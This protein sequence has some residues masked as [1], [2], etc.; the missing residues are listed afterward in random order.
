M[1]RENVIVVGSGG[2]EHTLADLLK[3]EGRMIFGAP[4]NPGFVSDRP[5]NVGIDGT[6]PE[7][8]QALYDFAVSNNVGMIVVGPE[9][10]LCDGLV[11]F[12]N[13]KG[14][15]RV[16]VFGPTSQAA[17]LE[18]DKFHSY[19]INDGLGIPQAR[20]IIC[21][22]VEQ[23]PRRALDAIDALVN[24]H[25]IVLKDRGLTGGKG[26]S[27]YDSAEKARKELLSHAY[28]Y[29]GDILVAERLKGQE[30]SVFCIADGENVKPI[31][32]SFQDHKP[33]LDGDKG[34]NTGGM[35]AYGPA[36]IADRG[37]VARVCGKIAGPIVRNTG[38]QGFLYL[39]MMLD[40]RDGVDKVIEY[41]VRFGD[42]E[43]QP[44]GMLLKRGLY[45]PLRLALEGRLDEAEFEFKPGAAVCVVLATPGY[46]TSEYKANTKRIIHGLEAVAEMENVKAYHAG[47]G[48]DAE[49]NIIN[50]G[51]RVLGITAYGE[52]EDVFESIK[53]AQKLAYVAAGK[54]MFGDLTPH[55]RSDIGDKA[56]LLVT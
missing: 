25:G 46:P 45:E 22:K 8:F 23:F 26:V 20:S 11:N 48:F 40:E 51:G 44:L 56:F 36:P 50:T 7:N 55:Y 24:E 12:I 29:S 49:L 15:E 17:M 3:G 32:I 34:P 2:R 39:G 4:G 28:T 13:S 5:Q 31:L 18:A 47:T 9:G 19:R 16:K 38:F 30:Y 10:P 43:A 21:E 52:G 42:P 37:R 33:L 41:N 14:D 27:V 54:I 53:T 35:G 1:G 6:K